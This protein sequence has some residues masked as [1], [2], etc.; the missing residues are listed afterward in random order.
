MNSQELKR[1]QYLGV[2]STIVIILVMPAWLIRKHA[3]QTVKDM[4]PRD[5]VGFVGREKCKEC[6]QKEYKAWT[7]SDHDRSMAEATQETVLGDF[8]NVRFES[9]GVISFFYKSGERFMVRTEGPEGKI[10][11][12][13]VKYTFGFDPLQ[14]YLIPFP[15]GRLQ[16]L[17]IAWDNDEKRWYDLYPKER[18]RFDDW[19]HW[20]RGAQNWNGMCAECHSTNLIKG[21]DAAN[22]SFHTTWS[23]I[24]VSCEA[25]HGPG[26]AHVKWAEIEAMAR[27]EVENF[28]L[29]VRTRDLSANQEV[30]LCAPCHSRRAELGDYNHTQTALMDAHLPVLLTEPLYYADGQIKDEVYVWGSFTQ[31][32]MYAKNVRC[33]DCHD[34]HSLAHKEI[35]NKLCLQCHRSDAYDTSKHHFHKKIHEGKPSDGALCVK[36]HMPE[37]TYMGIDERADH[38]I[39]VPRPD[40][41]NAIGTPNACSQ[42]GCHDD[43]DLSWTLESFTKWYGE[44]QKNHFATTIA[45]GRKG[46]PEALPDLLRLAQDPLYP[47]VVRATALSLLNGYNTKECREAFVQALSDEDALVRHTG[48][49]NIFLESPKELT[50]VVSPLLFDP[51]K[52]VRMQAAVKLADVPGALLREY[53]QK[54]IQQGIKDYE[55]SMR[56]SLDFSHAGY[57]LG[58]L[59]QRLGDSSK[60]EQYF[61]EAI[62][63]DDLFFPAKVNLAV[64]L[65]GKGRNAEAE[66]LLRSVVEAHPTQYDAM[67]A[68]GLLLGEMKKYREAEHFLTKAAEGMPDHPGAKRNLK[69]I[70]DF[71]AQFE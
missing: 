63:V 66:K 16:C 39:R 33:S 48:V 32:K 30:E 70:R 20:S 55:S 17:T 65:S 42:A 38:S 27:P 69:A 2:V 64:L 44:A 52:A 1:W 51:Q 9:N 21:F 60:A 49:T 31:S 67:Y 14:Q 41:T 47:A 36:C 10:G 68:L 57:N 24:D 61:R 53:Q 28:D 46:N 7:G 23:E 4:G 25:C 35:G 59:F 43:K 3:A 22:K 37:T 58:N 56:R 13:E 29:L 45:A 54:A 12:F 40:L 8:D 19:L 15:G 34:A 50:R 71:L 5:S 6:H 26:A 62:A 18:I 11:E